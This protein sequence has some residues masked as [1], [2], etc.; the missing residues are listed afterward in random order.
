VKQVGQCPRTRQQQL[1]QTQL[2]CECFG[3]V[4]GAGKR[5]GAQCMG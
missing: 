5:G 2:K 3:G 4:P 1:H